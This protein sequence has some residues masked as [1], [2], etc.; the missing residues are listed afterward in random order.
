MD[1]SDIDRPITVTTRRVFCDGGGALG[2]PGVYLNLD[3]SGRIVCPYCSRTFVL[4][5]KAPAE[6]GH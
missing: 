1:A 5:P 2:H 6:S 4:D 3:A